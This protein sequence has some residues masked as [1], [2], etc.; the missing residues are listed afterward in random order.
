MGKRIILDKQ[1]QESLWEAFCDQEEVM[2]NVLGHDVRFVV[3]LDDQ[4]D[5]LD[6]VNEI[7]SDPDLQSMLMASELDVAENRLYSAEEVIEHLKRTW[8]G[9]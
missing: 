9:E 7:E 1:A 4:S 3:T 8:S 6:M 2:V 5:F